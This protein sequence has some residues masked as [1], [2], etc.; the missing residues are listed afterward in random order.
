MGAPFLAGVREEWG[1][2]APR[3]RWFEASGFA[4]PHSASI[5]SGRIPH[6]ENREMWGTQD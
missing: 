3:I 6:F 2:S 5:A 4:R 1:S